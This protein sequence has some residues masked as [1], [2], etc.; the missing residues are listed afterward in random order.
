MAPG[1]GRQA[2]R[3]RGSTRFTARIHSR[4]CAASTGNLGQTEREREARAGAAPLPK[5]GRGPER[6][7]GGRPHSLVEGDAALPAPPVVAG[8]TAQRRAAPRHGCPAATAA[9]RRHAPPRHGTRPPIGCHRPPIPASSVPLAREPRLP[10][11]PRPP[12]FPSEACFSIGRGGRCRSSRGRRCSSASVR[13]KQRGRR[14]KWEAN[15]SQP[16]TVVE[17]EAANGKR[18]S[19][20]PMGAALP[21]PYIAGPG[22]RAP[23]P[24]ARWLAVGVG[25]RS[26]AGRCRAA[27]PLSAG[28]QLR[29][30]GSR[31]RAMGPGQRPPR[32]QHLPAERPWSPAAGGGSGAVLRQP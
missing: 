23:F 21:V 22:E 30:G 15:Q 9:G 11:P 4:R 27:G 31:S 3:L 32:A 18:R 8:G 24:T 7:R 17:E 2:W 28:A 16:V 13:R 12:A 10:P 6:R 29:R 25:P 14:W 1:P 20:Q 26:A 19:S 5:P